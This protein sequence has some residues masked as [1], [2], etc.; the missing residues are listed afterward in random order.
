MQ[1]FGHQ[2]GDAMVGQPPR[3]VPRRIQRCI[4]SPKEAAF[5]QVSLP[6]SLGWVGNLFYFPFY[7]LSLSHQFVNNGT[8]KGIGQAESDEDGG[9]RRLDMW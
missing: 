6:G 2:I 7:P 4:P 5:F 1:A 3:P 9:P 8:G